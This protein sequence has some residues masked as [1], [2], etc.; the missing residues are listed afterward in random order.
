MLTGYLRTIGNKDENAE[1][2][3]Q[4]P[5][6]AQSV[7]TDHCFATRRA[8]SHATWVE[9]GMVARTRA[10]HGTNVQASQLCIQP[11]LCGIV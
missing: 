10:F 11:E 3:T 5:G 1:D 8:G 6:A 7:V 4:R 2:A 9:S